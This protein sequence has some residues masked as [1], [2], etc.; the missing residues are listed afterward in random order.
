VPANTP[1]VTSEPGQDRPIALNGTMQDRE[2]LAAFVLL[3][4]AVGALLMGA[5]AVA[6]RRAEDEGE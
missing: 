2:Y 4:I 5:A 6:A 3:C 1:I